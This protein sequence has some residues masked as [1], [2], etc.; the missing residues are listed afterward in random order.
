VSGVPLI[1]SEICALRQGA[2]G[3][4]ETPASQGIDQQKGSVQKRDRSEAECDAMDKKG[5]IAAHGD[6]AQRDYFLH[7]EGRKYQT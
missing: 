3:Q 6:E 7:A 2:T 4:Q 1:A 5:D